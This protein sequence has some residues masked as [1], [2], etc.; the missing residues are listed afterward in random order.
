M[1]NNA[2]QQYILPW[3]LLKLIRQNYFL[4]QKKSAKRNYVHAIKS[5]NTE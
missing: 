1:I 4:S 5:E 3:K 2:Y